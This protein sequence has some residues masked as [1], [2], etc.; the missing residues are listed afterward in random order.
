MKLSQH[1]LFR[2]REL[3]KKGN[4]NPD[5]SNEELFETLRLFKKGGVTSM[6]LL[7][8]LLGQSTDPQMRLLSR[9]IQVNSS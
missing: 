7:G 4:E 8:S 1:E 2:L 9:I 5:L 3:V 6:M